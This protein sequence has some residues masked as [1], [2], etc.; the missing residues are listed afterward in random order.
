MCSQANASLAAKNAILIVEFA[1][2]LEDRGMTTSRP[3]SR[4]RSC[5]ASKRDARS[6]RPRRRRSL[7]SMRQ[8]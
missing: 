4:R 3:R 5:G 2:Q 8:N 7:R 6:R 1:K